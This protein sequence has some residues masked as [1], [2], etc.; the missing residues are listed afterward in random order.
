MNT[1]IK[2]IQF[3]EGNFLRSFADWMITRM[4]R[5]TDFNGNV[6]VI[7]PIEQGRIAELNRQNGSYHIVMKGLRNGL[8]VREIERIDCIEAGINPYTDFAAYLQAAA[9]PY[10]RFVISNTTE[11]GI[12]FDGDCLFTDKPAK[13]FPAKLTQFLYKRFTY[14]NGD[15]QKG[16]IFLPCELID[17]NGDKLK[18]CILQYARLW[19]LG[20]DF[21]EWLEQSNQ[22]TNTLVDRIVTGYPHES[23]KEIETEIGCDDELISESEIFHLWVIEGGQSVQKEFPA[24]AAGLNVLFVPE[25]KPYRDRKVTLLNGAHTVLAP[26]AYLYGLNTVREGA[27]NPLIGAFLEKIT[28]EELMPSLDLPRDELE[29]FAAAVMERFKNPYIRHQLTGIMLNS[30]SKYKTRDLPALKSFVER[31]K[32]LPS[33]LVAGLAAICVYY[34]GKKRGNDPI[35][36]SDDRF[37]LSLLQQAWRNSSPEET[38]STVL[39]STELWGE[40]LTAIEGLQA[41]L[42]GYI[43]QITEQGID[44]VINEIISA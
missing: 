33:G 29:S 3:G 34:R 7:Q 39:Q 8:P 10:L 22:F 31:N 26:V 17:R 38:A 23:A 4:N 42:S 11:S 36:L 9:L 35:V 40:N 25:M 32:K 21:E 43:K 41:K 14:F 24:E 16:L 5:E 6:I 30:F 13:S 15:T 1:P 12:A 20:A 27:E 28:T 18:E 19:Q 37:T 2:V 44:A